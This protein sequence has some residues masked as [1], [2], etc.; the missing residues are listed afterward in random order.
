MRS[1][2]GGNRKLGSNLTKSRFNLLLLEE[3]EFYLE[4]RL[5]VVA[6]IDDSKHLLG[7]LDL[8]VPSPGFDR[9]ELRRM[10]RPVRSLVP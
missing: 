8:P 9:E 1:G 10:P 6:P 3:G 4:V 7:L 2:A 5:F